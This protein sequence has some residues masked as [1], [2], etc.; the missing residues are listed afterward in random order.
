M[1]LLWMILIT[2]LVIAVVFFACVG[3]IYQFPN[4]FVFAIMPFVIGFSEFILCWILL[5]GIVVK[6]GVLSPI[7]GIPTVFGL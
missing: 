3:I 2:V 4:D 6:M 1:N 5:Y 7:P